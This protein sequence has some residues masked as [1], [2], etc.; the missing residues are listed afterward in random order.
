MRQMQCSNRPVAL[1]AVTFMLA[2]AGGWGT[3]P[4]AAS[5]RVHD[6]P[7]VRELDPRNEASPGFTGVSHVSVRN[8]TCGA[9]DQAIRRGYLYTSRSGSAAPGEGVTYHL[10]TPGFACTQLSG[11][12]A[13]AT[14]RC[15][16]ARTTAFRFTYGT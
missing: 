4:S 10:R 7:Y 6:C 15:M 3:L 12:I 16:R 1:V 13:G 14:I 11:G 8:M 9:A 2:V 5:A